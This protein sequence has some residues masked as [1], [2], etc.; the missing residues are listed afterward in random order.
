MS[1]IPMGVYRGNH[2]VGR[3]IPG[4]LAPR[5]GREGRLAAVPVATGSQPRP[6][7]D[8]RGGIWPASRLCRRVAVV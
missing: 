8:A 6:R 1:I 3:G 4:S 5:G 2:A 7:D